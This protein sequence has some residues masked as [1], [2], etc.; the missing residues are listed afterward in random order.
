MPGHIYLQ[1]GDYEL[2]AQ[3]NV[4]ASD[5][6]KAFV[7]RTGATGMYPL[8]YYTHNIHFI[9]Y[10]RAQQGRYDEAKQAALQMVKN[11][12]NADAQMQMLEGFHLY[13]LMIDL[14]FQRW[15]D[16]LKAEDPGP[17]RKL[18][19]SFRHYARAMALAGQGKIAEAAAERKLFETTRKGVPAESQ[20]LN[21][22]KAADI[23]SPGRGHSRRPACLG[24][25]PKRQVH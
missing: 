9:S 24:R 2:A 14:R 19:R 13:P 8:M 7:E 3:T 25:R 16:I 11:V 23:L 20:F 18:H 21:N 4:K 5:A 22:N 15:D 1:T 10:A 12:G 17:E 6:D